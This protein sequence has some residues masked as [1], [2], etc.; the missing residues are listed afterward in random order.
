MGVDASLALSITALQEGTGDLA[1]P[2]IN[3]KISDVVSFKSGTDAVTK[4]DVLW[5]DTRTLAASASESLDL[6]GSLV[7]AFGA[8]VNP[9]EIVAIYVKAKSTN[10]NDVV[11]GNA[12]SNGF[13]GPL[14]ATGTLTL[15]AG[16]FVLLSSQ[17]GWAVTAGTGDLLKVANSAAGTS[18]TYSIMIIG[19]S[20]AA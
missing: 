20:V 17:A 6:R 18:V 8:S 19:R 1:I 13:A 16:E 12:A 15:K 2:S 4:A 14:S 3:V 5:S 11:I 9:A 10:T 7:D